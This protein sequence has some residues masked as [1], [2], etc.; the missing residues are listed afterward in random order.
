[1]EN[2][3]L[4]IFHKKSFYRVLFGAAFIREE[5]ISLQRNKLAVQCIIVNHTSSVACAIRSTVIAFFEVPKLHAAIL[6]RINHFAGDKKSGKESHLK[7]KLHSNH[8]WD[9]SGKSLY[10]KIYLDL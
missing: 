1:M 9:K 3:N 7:P 2:R 8:N 10:S 6:I 4:R 5:I